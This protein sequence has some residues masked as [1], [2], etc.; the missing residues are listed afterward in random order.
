M[1]RRFGGTVLVSALAAVVVFIVLF[2]N[3]GDDSDP[4]ECFSK[5]DYVV[6]CGFGPDQAQGI[7]FAL[8]GA[9]LSV[10]LVGAG[11]AVGRWEGARR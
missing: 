10:V 5:F 6:P 3:G 7:G 9:M 11:A 8:A 1:I 4:P 2:P